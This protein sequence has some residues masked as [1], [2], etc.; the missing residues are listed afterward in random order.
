ME[1][2]SLD[3]EEK[4]TINQSK[5][6]LINKEINLYL[7]V[8]QVPLI[9]DQIFQFLDKDSKTCF[10]LCSKA[11]YKLCCD[12]ISKIE[13]KENI[14]D[15]G[16]FALNNIPNKYKN[17]KELLFKKCNDLNYY[18]SSFLSNFKNLE[19][20]HI[21]KSN[22]VD[23]SFLEKNIK[24]KELK[25][26]KCEIKDVFSSLSK[27]ENLL[28]LEVIDSNIDIPFFWGRKRR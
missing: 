20:L 3:S 9:L 19:V 28:I 27:L 15:L 14:K 21:Y 13:I 7:K 18:F 24:I 16:V 8:L 25:L 4:N 1:D 2:K 5:E 17:V 22:I 11:I 6:P 10:S 12:R 23:F 26:I